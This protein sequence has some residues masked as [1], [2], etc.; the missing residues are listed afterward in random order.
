MRRRSPKGPVL[1]LI[2]QP[3][4]NLSKTTLE[5]APTPRLLELGRRSQIY[6]RLG[7]RASNLRFPLATSSIHC[8]ALRCELREY[9]ASEVL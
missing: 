2:T 6:T 1:F 9:V 8:L 5:P 7:G 3:P 4:L